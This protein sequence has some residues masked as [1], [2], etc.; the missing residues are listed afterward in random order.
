MV[1]VR[2]DRPRPLASLAF[3]RQI[4]R[5]VVAGALAL[6]VGKALLRGI[7]VAMLL[8]AAELVECAC[9]EN[10]YNCAKDVGLLV[11]KSWSCSDTIS[12]VA[13]VMRFLP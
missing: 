10:A 9:A 4:S 8:V 6:Q 13:A 1:V 5:W 2:L 7:H 12:V 3:K 11:V